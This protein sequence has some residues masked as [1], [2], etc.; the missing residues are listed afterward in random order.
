MRWLGQISLMLMGY[1]WRG[2]V[3]DYKLG[4][5][6]AVSG[7][8]PGIIFIAPAVFTR[9]RAPPLLSIPLRYLK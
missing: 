3:S 1:Q 7:E 9:C 6:G 2:Y 8:W 4:F 5:C